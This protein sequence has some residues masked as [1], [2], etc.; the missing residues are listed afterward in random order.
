MVL[1]PLAGDPS[2]PA[3]AKRGRDDDEEE[4]LT[5]L[6][7]GVT[8]LNGFWAWLANKVAEYREDNFVYQSL[9]S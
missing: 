2:S 7:F 3:R 6:K 8:K 1:Q 4:S 5:N 9:Q